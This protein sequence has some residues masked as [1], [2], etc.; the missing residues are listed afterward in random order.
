MV[1]PIKQ[2]CEC[3]NIPFKI[4]HLNKWWPFIHRRCQL[5]Q[6][7]TSHKF[8]SSAE[9][10]FI[11]IRLNYAGIY[12]FLR[13]TNRFYW[14]HWF[15]LRIFLS[16]LQ[17]HEFDECRFDVSVNNCVWYLRAETPEDKLNWIEVLQSYNVW[18]HYFNFKHFSNVFLWF[19]TGI[20]GIGNGSTDAASLRRHGS[21]ISLQSNTLSTTSGSSL[22]RANRSLR[23]KVYEIET[24]KDILF[25]Q[26]ET[27]Q[28][29]DVVE[30]C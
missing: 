24:F 14:S 2:L 8:Q 17:S 11:R 5:S 3:S 29:W 28:R 15:W 18:L 16:H 1:W 26:I 30:I 23:E 25:G 20:G 13:S 27:L 22:K 9:H 12:T 10:N 6:A 19:Q 7:T 21:T 4:Y